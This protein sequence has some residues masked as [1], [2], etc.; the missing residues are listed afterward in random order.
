MTAPACWSPCGSSPHTRGALVR[1]RAVG[2]GAGIIPAYAGSTAGSSCASPTQTDHPRIRGEHAA[3]SESDKWDEGSSPHTRG[4]RK[5][6]AR[7]SPGARIIPAYAGSTVMR[8]CC[9]G[10]FSDHP[11]IRGEH[12]APTATTSVSLGSSP[13]TRGAPRHNSWTNPLARDHPRIRGEHSL[14]QEAFVLAM[15]SSP[16]TRGAL[17]LLKILPPDNGIIPAYAGSTVGNRPHH[18]HQPDHPRIR[19][20]HLQSR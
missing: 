14:C 5:S 16:H 9:L 20:E 11:R 2:D 15:G 1:E 6:T 8:S 13:H 17:D 7:P 12:R 18:R 19:G 4:A 3:P 10:S